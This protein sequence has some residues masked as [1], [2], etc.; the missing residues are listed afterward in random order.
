MNCYSEVVF[1]D[2][3]NNNEL[4]ET[5]S[6]IGQRIFTADDKKGVINNDSIAVALNVKKSGI[7]LLQFF[8]CHCGADSITKPN[9]YWEINFE[10][11]YSG[12]KFLNIPVSGAWDNTNI[13]NTLENLE[14]GTHN[15]TFKNQTGATT[16][17]EYL[18]RAGVVAYLLKSV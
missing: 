2:H 16:S 10:A 1:A 5:S 12:R 11:A 6:N 8:V 18:T 17:S 4:K 7:Y 15:F 9:A 13:V 14:S 3:G